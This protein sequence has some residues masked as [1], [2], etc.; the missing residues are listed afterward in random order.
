MSMSASKRMTMSSYGEKNVVQRMYA[1]AIGEKFS[2][3]VHSDT[4]EMSFTIIHFSILSYL[5]ANCVSGKFSYR[6][7]IE[8]E[9]NDCVIPTYFFFIV[10]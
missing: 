6:Y 4:N 3:D 10:R 8:M 2:R 9:E 7:V 1:E 5:H